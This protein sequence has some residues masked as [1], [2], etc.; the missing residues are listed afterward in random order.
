MVALFRTALSAWK[1]QILGHSWSSPALSKITSN[2][3]T[4]AKQVKS[5][6]NT[7][8]LC[9]MKTA[10]SCYLY[11]VNKVYFTF[12]QRYR[13]SPTHPRDQQERPGFLPTE[14]NAKA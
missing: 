5:E 6:V 12:Q 4:L 2:L 8:T 9:A 1:M 11:V 10:P 3:P 14:G 13:V 7:G